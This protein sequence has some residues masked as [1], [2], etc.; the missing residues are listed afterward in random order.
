MAGDPDDSNME[1]S[2]VYGWRP[3]QMP[4]PSIVMTPHGCVCPAGSEKTCKGPMCP[5]RNPFKK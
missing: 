1:W 4:T 5:R 2:A 3:K